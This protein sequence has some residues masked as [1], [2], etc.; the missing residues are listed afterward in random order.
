MQKV[1][2]NVEEFSTEHEGKRKEA[3]SSVVR[4]D[5]IM[6]EDFPVEQ[7]DDMKE[8]VTEV[9]NIVEVGKFDEKCIE[10][11]LR[12]KKIVE[13]LKMKNKII[14]KSSASSVLKKKEGTG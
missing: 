5:S 4:E 3:I 1:E 13:V 7:V 8:A 14:K 10:E 12:K 2:G 11:G 9:R 6:K